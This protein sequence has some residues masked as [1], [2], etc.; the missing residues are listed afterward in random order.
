MGKPIKAIK[1]NRFGK[2][3]VP[4]TQKVAAW[5]RS[6]H[7]GIAINPVLGEVILSKSGIDHSIAKGTVIEPKAAAFEAVPDVIEK[8][9]IVHLETN[10]KGRGYDTYTIAAPVEILG[11]HR[12]VTVV[13]M[14]EKNGNRFTLQ[15]VDVTEKLRQ[16]A[17][18]SG[19]AARSIAGSSTSAAAPFRN[20]LLEIFN[21]NENDVSKV[22]DAHG[23]PLVVY[24]GTESG[25]LEAFLTGEEVGRNEPGIFFSDSPVTADY[26]AS[27]Y[28]L[29][30]QFA[31]YDQKQF[32][33]A[34]Q[35]EF[36]EYG[37]EGWMAWPTVY[38][39]F[40]NITAPQKGTAQNIDIIDATE[41][42]D[43]AKRDGKNG[44]IV[45]DVIETDDDKATTYV[46]FSPNQIKSVNNQGTFSEDVSIL[47]SVISDG[48]NSESVLDSLY[49]NNGDI[50]YERVQ[51]AV[52]GINEG[53]YRIQ[54]LTPAGEEGRLVGDNRL[55]VGSSLIIGGSQR[56][57]SESDS[58]KRRNREEDLLEAYAKSQ[59]AW[60]DDID[61]FRAPLRLV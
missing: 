13:V 25:D 17:Q 3:G 39:V 32:D 30:N 26:F 45:T 40:L 46:V 36:A 4:L 48:A 23:E 54:R 58:R 28:I 11:K 21:V 49:D 43:K 6:D 29:P 37:N 15:R 24:H 35:N 14:K 59:N 34:L 31:R 52:T 60:V 33:D 18:K 53:K 22:V 16:D 12:V 50:D 10:W 47:K 2:D 55:L 5:F 42:I 20:I 41:D 57:S 8:G 19:S 56:A 38:P 1:V 27:K 9:R 61:G 44:L 51:N 7:N